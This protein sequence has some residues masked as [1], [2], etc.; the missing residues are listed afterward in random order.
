VAAVRRD[1][2]RSPWKEECVPTQ[3]IV[4]VEIPA[5]DLEAASQFYAQVFDWKLD[6]SMP[7][8]PQ[9][10]AEGGPSGGFVAVRDEAS[11]HGLKYRPGEV[12]IYLSTDDIDAALARVEE[13]GGRTL[14]PRTEIPTIGYWAMFEDPTGNRIG[15]YSTRERHT[16]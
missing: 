7:D 11:E 2:D 9:F 10:Q 4:H 13:Y 15:L 1:P 14:L 12:L 8:Y 3:P 16:V 5:R 6:M